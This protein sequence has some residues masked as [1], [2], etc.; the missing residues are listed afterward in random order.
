MGNADFNKLGEQLD[1]DQSLLLT[2]LRDPVTYDGNTGGRVGQGG[3]LIAN[4]ISQIM[5][6]LLPDWSE[7]R[8]ENAIAGLEAHGL[9]EGLSS[10]YNLLATDK[11]IH[12]L[13]NKLTD[14]GEKYAHWLG[15]TLQP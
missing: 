10:T 6:T 9:I 1:D 7:A 12:M 3:R 14:K 13:R 4:S 11:G 5:K 8:I 15:S 2:I